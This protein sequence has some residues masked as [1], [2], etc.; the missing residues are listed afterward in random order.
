M[1]LLELEIGKR[2][3]VPVL[4]ETAQ[5]TDVRNGGKYQK[6]VARDTDGQ[7]V[8]MNSFLKP[9]RFLS[10][11]D[12]IEAVIE[13]G[14]YEGNKT[15]TLKDYSPS[16]EKKSAFM[17]KTKIDINSTWKEMSKLIK[18]IDDERYCRLACKVI[19]NELNT[20]LHAPLTASD[21]YARDG[22][23]LEATFK[24]MQLADSAAKVLSLDRN[25]LLSAA[26]VYYS[27]STM[28][29]DEDYQPTKEVA[30]TGF[31]I[32][33]HDKLVMANSM[34]SED[35]RLDDESFKLFDNILLSRYQGKPIASK[36]AFALK[37]LDS[38]VTV[39]ERG[40]KIIEGLTEGAFFKESESRM[41]YRRMEDH[42]NE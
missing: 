41:W 4:I 6:L 21:E 29:V 7:K 17:P 36:E 3:K 30:L 1:C 12:I 15:Y 23:L 22:G 24:L 38:V 5:T 16:N 39:V 40:D 26:A 28:M 14:E 20:F 42:D 19:S 34:I 11:K 10:D 35:K 37:M 13:A 8:K 27:G 25:L 2:V 9:E 31:D 33:A 18:T 32:A